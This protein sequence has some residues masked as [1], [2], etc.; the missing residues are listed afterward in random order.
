MH[1][2]RHFIRIEAAPERVFEAVSAREGVAGWW[3]PHVEG[4]DADGGLLRFT[5]NS[6]GW[7]EMRV[8]E[9]EAPRR[10]RWEFVTSDQGDADE[11][12]GTEVVFDLEP[13]GDGT[14]LRFTH[15]GWGDDRGRLADC[16]TS[17]GW[18][19]FSLKRLVETGTGRPA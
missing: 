16:N 12:R 4:D 5:F 1:A 2:I 18:F 11:W 10:L 9:R 14:A 13:A 17:W 19:M 7:C 3:T 6:G 15:G 8:A